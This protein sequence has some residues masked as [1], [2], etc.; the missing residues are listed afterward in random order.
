MDCKSKIKTREELR[1]ILPKHGV[2]FANGSFD[3]VHARHALFLE[4]AKRLGDVLVVGVNSDK[5]VKEWKKHIG[6][7]DY[8]KRPIIPERY[9]SIMVAAIKDVDYVVI[10]NEPT[11]IELIKFLRPGIFV[12][13]SDYGAD[14][15]ERPI[16]QEYGGVVKIIHIDADISTSAIMQKIKEA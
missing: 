1:R 8:D 5:S 3:I 9:R 11:P 4:E 16:V 6:Y 12:N 14:C 10:F 2:V 13:G 7:K 15:I